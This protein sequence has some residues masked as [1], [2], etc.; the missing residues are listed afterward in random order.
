M[1]PRRL[2]RP[3]QPRRRSRARRVQD[4]VAKDAFASYERA[5]SGFDVSLFRQAH[6]ELGHYAALSGFTFSL[7]DPL[8]LT[9]HD[10]RD[11]LHL[12]DHGYSKLGRCSRPSESG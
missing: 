5:H 4:G 2:Q 3:R 8:V 7:S 12:H 11:N 10:F 1:A 9:S 6:H